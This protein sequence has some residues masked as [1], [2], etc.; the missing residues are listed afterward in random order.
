MWWRRRG[1]DFPVLDLALDGYPVERLASR[2]SSGKQPPCGGPRG[3]GTTSRFQDLAVAAGHYQELVWCHSGWDS[4]SCF[5]L[6]FAGRYGR[7]FLIGLAAG[8]LLSQGEAS[9]GGAAKKRPRNY[10]ITA[11]APTA[12]ANLV[13]Q[14]EVEVTVRPNL[15][16]KRKSTLPEI[17]SLQ[18][19]YTIDLKGR[20]AQAAQA[21]SGS[22]LGLSSPDAP[23]GGGFPNY[24]GTG[25]L[26]NQISIKPTSEKHLLGAFWSPA[27]GGASSIDS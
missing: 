18:R 19:D 5:S 11:G 24:F 1:G 20:R 3:P 4:V 7:H 27:E 17:W 8:W 23:L 10:R 25:R 15:L 14:C 6:P 22:S 12:D 26:P 21:S 13:K 2:R 16:G 9:K